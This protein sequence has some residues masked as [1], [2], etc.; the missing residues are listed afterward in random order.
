M[1]IQSLFYL[2]LLNHNFKIG[3]TSLCLDFPL[4]LC[5]ISLND[6]F[7]SLN[8]INHKLSTV[9]DLIPNIFLQ[10]C[11]FVL[12]NT[13]HYLFNLSLS[14]YIF[15]DFR[16]SNLVSPIHKS[17]DPSNIINYNP[18]SLLSLIPKIFEDFVSKQIIPTLNPKIQSDRYVKHEYTD[19]VPVVFALLSLSTVIKLF[20]S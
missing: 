2:F 15:P 11:K 18:I 7:N 13:L 10:H 17:V 9:R 19:I 5:S 4:T 12:T 3:T 6:I 1:S 16:E 14:S 20:L 8:S